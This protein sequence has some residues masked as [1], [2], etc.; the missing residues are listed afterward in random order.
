MTP[1]SLLKP[2][3]ADNAALWAL[4]IAQPAAAQAPFPGRP[5][6]LTAPYAA[7]GKVNAVTRWIA[8]QRA[9]QFVEG[10]Q[11]KFGEIVR[12]RHIRAE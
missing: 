1:S 3:F 2:A 6:T 8:P 7:G 9:R 11:R 10:E 4:C 5:V 12:Q